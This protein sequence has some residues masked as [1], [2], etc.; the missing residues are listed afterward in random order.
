MANNIK[1]PPIGHH[2][3]RHLLWEEPVST[4]NKTLQSYTRNLTIVNVN[5]TNNSFVSENKSTTPLLM[6][7]T[8]PTIGT[9]Y[10]NQTESV[11]LAAELHRWIG[12]PYNTTI[13]EY[14]TAPAPKKTKKVKTKSKLRKLQV[15]EQKQAELSLYNLKRK[16]PEDFS[17]SG[18][19]NELQLFEP[20][21]FAEFFAAINRKDDTFYV[22]SF[23]PDHLLLPALNHNKTRRPK[24][25]LIFPA[26]LANGK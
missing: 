14:F 1:E 10:F 8:P 16:Q 21:E 19:V 2:N 25:S 18:S 7:P 15:K 6:C 26:V 13:E 5:T 9:P 20:T 22:V 12:K 11:R 3:G 4:E 24:M 23:S 17:T